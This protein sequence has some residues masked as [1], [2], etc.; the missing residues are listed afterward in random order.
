MALNGANPGL[1]L[2]R[3]ATDMGPPPHVETKFDRPL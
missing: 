3:R 2:I 1:G